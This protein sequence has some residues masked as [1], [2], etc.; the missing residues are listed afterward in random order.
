MMSWDRKRWIA[1]QRAEERD[2]RVQD[3]LR[4]E[5]NWSDGVTE[6]MIAD[7]CNEAEA[8]RTTPGYTHTD[9]K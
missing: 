9:S 1:V 2:N 7:R 3:A 4:D 5:N 8:R 6:V